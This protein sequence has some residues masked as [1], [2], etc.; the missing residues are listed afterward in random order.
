MKQLS[1]FKGTFFAALASAIFMHYFILTNFNVAATEG[2]VGKVQKVS[3]VNK[4]MFP[5]AEVSF[6]VSQF[7]HGELV[8]QKR[9]IKMVHDGPIKFK[10]GKTYTVKTHKDWLC[11]YSKS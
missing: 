5:K 10:I 1:K 8:K 11:S 9:I 7:L 2:F 3:E 6:E 4:G